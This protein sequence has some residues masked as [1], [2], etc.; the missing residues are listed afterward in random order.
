MTAGGSAAGTPGLIR[1]LTGHVPRAPGSDA[2]FRLFFESFSDR[3]RAIA[4]RAAGARGSQNGHSLANPRRL[5]HGRCNGVDWSRIRFASD[6]FLS[7]SPS[8]STYHR[9]A[10]RL[11]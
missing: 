11:L 6:N 3:A 10:W 2:T 8:Q 1:L 5:A 4:H 9:F 7:L